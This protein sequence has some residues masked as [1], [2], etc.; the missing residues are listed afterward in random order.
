MKIVLLGNPKSTSHI[1]HYHCKFGRPA[2]YMTAEG[3]KIKE[4]YWLQARSQCKKPL[5]GPLKV[6][7]ILFFQDRRARDWDNF[8]KL[9]MDALNGVVWV[10]DKQIIE[11][12]VRKSYDKENPRIELEISTVSES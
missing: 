11:A 9:S 1:Y 5:S 4:S 3:K 2:G 12:N 6:S 7:I 8:H 10:D